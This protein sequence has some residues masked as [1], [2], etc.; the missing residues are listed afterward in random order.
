MRF[1]LRTFAQEFISGAANTSGSTREYK[2]VGGEKYKNVDSPFRMKTIFWWL[3]RG[4]GRAERE[5]KLNKVQRAFKNMSHMT[6]RLGKLVRP[7]QTIEGESLFSHDPYTG[8]P[9]IDNVKR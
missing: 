5:R 3:F 8:R 1:S 2:R 4:E 9:F 6:S 7:L